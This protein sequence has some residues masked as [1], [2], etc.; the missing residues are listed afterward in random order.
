VQEFG[1]NVSDLV[2]PSRN[3]QKRPRVAVPTEEEKEAEQKLSKRAKKKM[4]QLQVPT[5]NVTCGSC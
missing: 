3:K 1:G 5:I 2:L 4:E